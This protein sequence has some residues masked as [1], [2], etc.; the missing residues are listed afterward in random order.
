MDPDQTLRDLRDEIATIKAK[1]DDVDVETEQFVELFDA[2]DEWL[3]KEGFLPGDWG[4]EPVVHTADSVKEE[5]VAA[6][7]HTC[8]AEAEAP[9]PVR[10]CTRGHG[11]WCCRAKGHPPDVHVAIGVT[12]NGT[13]ITSVWVAGRD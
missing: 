7:Y 13:E 9:C 8:R 3:S 11:Q 5:Q 4:R 10:D 1:A 6:D 2:L 12:A